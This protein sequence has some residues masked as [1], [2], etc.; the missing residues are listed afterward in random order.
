MINAKTEGVYARVRKMFKSVLCLPKYSFRILQVSDHTFLM[1]S[2]VGFYAL[3][4]LLKTSPLCFVK[5]LLDKSLQP[6]CHLQ[7]DQ[8]FTKRKTIEKKLTKDELKLLSLTIFFNLSKVFNIRF[9]HVNSSLYQ[10]SF[11]SNVPILR[12]TIVFFMPDDNLYTKYVLTS[13]WDTSQFELNYIDSR[14]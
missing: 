6:S 11:H 3:L 13:T 9:A 8:Y 14:K 2:T 4:Q 5:I 7:V 12:F 10:F 1:K